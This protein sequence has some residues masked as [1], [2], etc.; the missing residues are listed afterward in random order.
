[1]KVS[2]CLQLLSTVLWTLNVYFFS[3]LFNAF[4]K[5]WSLT[6][7]VTYKINLSLDS[8]FLGGVFMGNKIG[9]Y[10]QLSLL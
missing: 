2:F 1:M 10:V 8:V 7:S 5:V 4:R 6:H 3:H 9:V